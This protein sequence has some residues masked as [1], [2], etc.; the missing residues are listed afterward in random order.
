MVCSL[1]GL[2]VA[3]VLCLSVPLCEGNAL[4]AGLTAKDTGK[5]NM[6]CWGSN[7]MG[8]TTPPAL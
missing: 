8:K 6:V 3:T 7:N 1:A 5:A 2:S 4:A